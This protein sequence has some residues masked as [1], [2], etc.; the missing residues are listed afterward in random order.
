MARSLE[1]AST[2]LKTVEVR[3]EADFLN[4]IHS[5]PTILEDIYLRPTG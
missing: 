3:S 4:Q 2:A 5:C 1:D